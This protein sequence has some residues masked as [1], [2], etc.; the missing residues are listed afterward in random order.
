MKAEPGLVQFVKELPREQLERKFLLRNMQDHQRKQGYDAKV[1]AW[2]ERPEQVDVCQLKGPA[3]RLRLITYFERNCL[4]HTPRIRRSTT[5]PVFGPTPFRGLTC[6]RVLPESPS[7]LP[8]QFTVSERV[9]RNAFCGLSRCVAALGDA[10]FDKGWHYGFCRGGKR[11][12]ALKAR[13]GCY[14]R[15]QNL[16][17]PLNLRALPNALTAT[18]SHQFLPRPKPPD[19]L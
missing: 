6:L 2:L 1:K 3:N 8:A 9:P 13:L 14:R 19:L 15:W 7:A 16:A 10:R 18:R 4:P 5:S 12:L 17:P 11:S